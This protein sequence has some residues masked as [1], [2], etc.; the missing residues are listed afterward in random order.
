MTSSR[1]SA[2]AP[3]RP[4]RTRSKHDEDEDEET[5]IDSPRRGSARVRRAD[6]HRL[7]TGWR[8]L[9]RRR[10]EDG[11]GQGGSAEGRCR[12]SGGRAGRCARGGRNGGQGRRC[13]GRGRHGRRAEAA[14]HQQGRHGVH[15][16]RDHHGHPDDHP[17]PRAVLRRPGPLEEHAVGADAGVRGLRA[18]HRAVGDLRLLGGLH[19]R[20]ALL[21]RLVEDVPVGRH[22]GVGGGDVQQGRR[23]SPSCRSSPSRARS[24]PSPAR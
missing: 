12:R 23:T 2:S 5:S 13:A 10:H 9:A 22:A 1:S 11:T 19:R 21:R 14:Q 6:L 7:R 20:L 17:G 16:R 18:D 15:V 8:R 24:R 3:A 4:A